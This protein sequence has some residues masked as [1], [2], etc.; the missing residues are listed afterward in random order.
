MPEEAWLL[1]LIIAGFMMIVG[2]RKAALKLVFIIILIALLGPFMDS[3]LD[4]FPGWML[5]LLFVVFVFSIFRL[6]LGGRIFANVVSFLICD[7]IRAPFRIAWFL[8]T[9]A[10]RR[11]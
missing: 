9:R 3:L 1:I 11:I 8:L 10:G 6:L 2:L 4:A 7:L 5:V